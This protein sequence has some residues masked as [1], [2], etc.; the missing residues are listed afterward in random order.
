MTSLPLPISTNLLYKVGDGLAGRVIHSSYKRIN[1]FF[2][3]EI[4]PQYW[5]NSN[6]SQIRFGQKNAG[7]LHSEVQVLCPLSSLLG[8]FVCWG[9][10]NGLQEE[11]WDLSIDTDKEY[12]DGGWE[13]SF[14]ARV[15]LVWRLSQSVTGPGTQIWR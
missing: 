8:I 7:R 9:Q 3:V 14:I 10:S 12:W 15:I 11:Y 2:P 1:K 4:S 6:S 5:D 13:D